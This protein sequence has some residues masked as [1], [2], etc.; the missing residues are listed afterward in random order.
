MRN[1][2][3]NRLVAGEKNWLRRQIAWV[4]A[5]SVGYGG[6]KNSASPPAS[7]VLVGAIATPLDPQVQNAAVERP[8]EFIAMT[9]RTHSARRQK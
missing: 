5:L 4:G 2:R 9:R 8:V 6:E 1:P 7:C 3:P